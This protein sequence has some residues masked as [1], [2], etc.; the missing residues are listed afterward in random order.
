MIV[1]PKPD[2]DYAARPGIRHWLLAA[3]G[4]LTLTNVL[5]FATKLF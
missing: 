4:L 1:R 3:V 2:S 5:T